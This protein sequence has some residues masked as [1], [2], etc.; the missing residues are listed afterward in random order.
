[1]NSSGAMAIP[2]TITMNKCYTRSL[3]QGCGIEMGTVGMRIGSG[4]S[5]GH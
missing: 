4:R 2:A 3:G 5:N 1:M